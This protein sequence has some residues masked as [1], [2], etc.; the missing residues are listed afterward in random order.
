MERSQARWEGRLDI[1][2]F[3]NRLLAVACYVDR[4]LVDGFYHVLHP[5]EDTSIG[6]TWFS[7]SLSAGTS[8]YIIHRCPDEAKN[9]LLAF[10]KTTQATSLLEP[11]AT[12]VFIADETFRQWNMQIFGPLENLDKYVR[13]LSWRFM[14]LLEFIYFSTGRQTYWILNSSRIARGRGRIAL[15]VGTSS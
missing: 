7:L 15:D 3:D 13:L 11:F 1:T 14:T 9:L 10:S 4:S 6:M 5:D 8:T 2:G 12:D